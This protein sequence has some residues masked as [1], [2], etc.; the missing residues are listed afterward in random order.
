MRKTYLLSA[1]LGFFLL[2]IAQDK[3]FIF[4]TDSSVLGAAID[5]V[6]SLT[7][8]KDGTAL[9]FHLAGAPTDF[10]LSGIDSMTFGNGSDTISIEYVGDHVRVRNPLHFEGVVV[11]TNGADVT[12]TSTSLTKD[13][14]YRLS[15]STTEGSFKLYSA[16]ACNIL[17]QGVS[18][19]N[20][21][22]PAI[23]NQ[24]SKATNVILVGG[25]ENFLTDGTT[26]AAAPVVN[27]LPEDQGAAFFSEGQLIFG[28]TGKL[29]ITGKGSLQHALNSDDYV[30]VNSGTIIVANAQKDGIHG[31]DG[32][33]MKGGSVSVSSLSDGVDGGLGYV[34]ITGGV[35][36]IYSVSANVNGVCCDST[37][38]VSGGSVNIQVPGNQSKGLKSSKPMF[39]SGGD[40]TIVASGSAVLIALPIGKDPSYC[41]AIKCDSDLTI[42]GTTIQINHSGLGGK[43][44]TASGNVTMNSGSV[45][46]TTSGDGSTYTNNLNTLDAYSATCLSANGRVDLLGGTLSVTSTGKGGKG[47]SANGIL[48]IGSETGGPFITAA[49]SGASIL[50]TVSGVLTS[51]TEAKA[52]KSDDDFYILNGTTLI[53]TSGAGEGIDTKKSLY[54]EG[55]TTV[56]QGTATSSVKSVDYGTAFNIAGGTLMVSGPYR[57]TIKKP[58]AATQP[59]LYATLNATSATLAANAVF[60]IQDASAQSLASY[61]LKRAGYYFIY[62]SPSLKASTAY[63]IFTGGTATGSPLN[64]F[65]DGGTYSGGTKKGSFTT[66]TSGISTT[67]TN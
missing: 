64:G 28:G 55:G 52:L 17:L 58:T 21:D 63:S 10:L 18:I 24:S 45:T 13:I 44:I 34:N 4:K 6:D 31:N 49:T 12:V 62:S 46:I 54:V 3:L 22:G 38:T 43:G 27:G 65:Y 40:I 9:Q 53:N 15:G 25:T 1:F 57:T 32:F 8:S 41:A 47:V 5:A 11:T 23:N 36:N 60:N 2:L 66:T 14:T 30:E 35:L 33:I 26:Y 29:T 50:A 20:T 42:N 59:W 19:T 56:V 16:H 61:T 37:L 39:L 48:T 51:I 67:F 7:F